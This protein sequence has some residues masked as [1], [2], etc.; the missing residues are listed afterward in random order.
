M[1]SNTRSLSWNPFLPIYLFYT[2]FV[3]HFP[4]VLRPAKREDYL[5]DVNRGK[6]AGRRSARNE[7]DPRRHDPFIWSFA[8]SHSLRDGKTRGILDGITDWAYADIARRLLKANNNWYQ[9]PLHVPVILLSIFLDNAAWEVNVAAR[10]V[11]EFEDLSRAAQISSLEKFDIITSEL[12]CIRRS[13]QFQ[14]SLSKSML[15]TL[16]FLET[17]VFA[18]RWNSQDM[19]RYELYVYQTNPH[20]E[21]KLKNMLSLIENNLQTCVYL[22]SRS[23]DALDYVS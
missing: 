1:V 9:H 14:E 16:K 13:L 3:I 10:D 17:N 11:E 8:M 6:T 20:M 22:Q 5:N 18:R 4:F 21:E 19:S 23:K 12:Q 7:F 2:A 15:D